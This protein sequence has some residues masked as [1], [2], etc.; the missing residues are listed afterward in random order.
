MLHKG[1]S[2]QDHF[3]DSQDSREQGLAS[4]G[5]R[6]E[7]LLL[8][9]FC[10]VGLEFPCLLFH[11][12][13]SW[14]QHFQVLFI[15]PEGR[16]DHVDHFGSC[17]PSPPQGTMATSVNIATGFL[18]LSTMAPFLTLLS[19]LDPVSPMQ[20][21]RGFERVSKGGTKCTLN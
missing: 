7:Q 21:W 2:T 12:G 14:H 16:K 13:G 20:I 11:G 3:G 4:G 17:L 15:F 19:P 1:G 10:K 18:L 5:Y 9:L 8:Q 6:C